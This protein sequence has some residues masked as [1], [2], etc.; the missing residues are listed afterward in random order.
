MAANTAPAT[1]RVPQPRAYR[2]FLTPSLHR[3]FTKT[4]LV[5]LAACW[6]EA[7]L[8]S[9]PSR[10]HILPPTAISY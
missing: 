3:R 4:A 7:T 10:E 6:L 5:G 8:M 9:E 1:Q 2:D